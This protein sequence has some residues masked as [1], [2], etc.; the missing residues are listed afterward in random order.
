[1]PPTSLASLVSQIPPGSVWQHPEGSSSRRVLSLISS[2][3]YR[4]RYASAAYP[5]TTFE[6]PAD[7]FIRWISLGAER[8]D[9]PLE[10]PHDD[11][12]SEDDE[13]PSGQ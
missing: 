3:G 2:D 11:E 7:S 5:G 4:V 13:D 6:I 1:M 10:P 8:I 9:N 12:A